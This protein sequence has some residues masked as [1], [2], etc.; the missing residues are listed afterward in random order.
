MSIAAVLV[1]MSSAENPIVQTVYTADPAPMVHND[2]FYVYTG[3]D[4]DNSTIWFNMRE[5]RCYSSTDMANWTDRG[6][7]MNLTT[8]SWA[9]SDAWASH[10]IYR[11][12]KYYFYV[13]IKPKTGGWAIGVG[14]S[15][16]PAGPFTDAIG[17]PLVS[18]TDYYI[19]PVVYIDD[20]GQAYMFWGNPYLYYVKLNGDMISTSGSVSQ[21]TRN[22]ETFDNK[23]G[24]AP[25]FYK[26]K[27]LYYMLFAANGSNED[28]RYSTSSA[29]LG[30]W[31]YRGVIMPVQ[32]I[33]DKICWTNHE[34]VV[35]F[36]GN[37]YFVY[38]NGTIGGPFM[39]SVC[40]EQ[41]KYNADG[42]FPTVNMTKAGPAQVGHLNP[43]DTTQAE[44]ICWESGVETESCT[45]GGVDV[46]SIENGDYIK[47]K[48]VD[49]G[50]GASSF[51]ARVSSAAGGGTIEL[52]IDSL[53][54]PAAGTCLV[55]GTGGWQTWVAETCAVTGVSGVHDLYF[56]FTGGNGALF[57]FNWWKFSPVPTGTGSAGSNSARMEN[58]FKIITNNGNVKQLHLN[59]SPSVYGGKLSVCLFDLSGQ[60]VT[61]LFK[62]HLNSGNMILALEQAQIRPG[63]YVLRASVDKKNVF[64]K[65]VELTKK[66]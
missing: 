54:S 36:R 32:S 19:D 62:G 31:T 14:V 35:D 45:E 20:D 39:R 26:R 63:I 57:N 7:P 28:I 16:N 8:F 60:L 58:E 21:I 5:W 48:G 37:S 34:G 1:T 61:T 13:T 49:F 22:A 25:W 55:E 4:Q 52:H 56:K 11:N 38:H 43:Y 40:I 33:T 42:T 3:H 44:T 66:L 17:A 10:T 23:Y 64:T 50:D 30:P 2:T 27:D 59:F 47:V 53:N 24:E 18:F 15:A 9:A 51:T 12:G 6:S 65:T 46:C 29:P 41:F